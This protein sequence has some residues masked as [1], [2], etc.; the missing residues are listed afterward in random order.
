V[1]LHQHGKGEI[2][3]IPDTLDFLNEGETPKKKI[4]IT[5]EQA[6]AL[7]LSD[8]MTDDVELAQQYDSGELFDMD[9]LQRAALRRQMGFDFD[10]KYTERKFYVRS[11]EAPFVTA[12]A[13]YNGVID[14]QAIIALVDACILLKQRY[15]DAK[16]RRGL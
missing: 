2:M 14:E 11:K 8:G 1:I 12:Q 16:E 13:D 5:S 3:D 9:G 6:A 15:Q 4:G 10:V 7:Y